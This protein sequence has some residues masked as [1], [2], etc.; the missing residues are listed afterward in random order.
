[1]SISD[2]ISVAFERLTQAHTQITREIANYPAP[3]SGCDAQFNHLLSLRTRV[4][5]ALAALTAEPFVP[6]PR[7]LA[8]GNQVESR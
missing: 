5:D 4:S 3:I 6:T 1:M 8:P 7:L 2:H